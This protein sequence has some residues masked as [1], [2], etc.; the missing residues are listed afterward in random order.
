MT[1]VDVESCGKNEKPELTRRDFTIAGASAI[2]AAA[3][4]GSA[5]AA[6]AGGAMPMSISEAGKR[7]RDGSLSCVDLTKAYYHYI[8]LYQPKLNMF[9]SQLKDMAL[10]TAAERDAELA[11]LKAEIYRGE[12]EL[13]VRRI[14]AHDRF[15]DRC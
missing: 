4:P 14:D 7:M 13:L 9:I 12:I 1:R 15:S 2:A 5:F 3:L 11:F 8:E 10:K 6:K